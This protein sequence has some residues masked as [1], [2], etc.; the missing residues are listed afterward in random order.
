MDRYNF[1]TEEL[2]HFKSRGFE[3]LKSSNGGYY[4]IPLP[5]E[6]KLLK[7]LKD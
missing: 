7:M 2:E 1:S 3:I 6:V 4:L 5:E